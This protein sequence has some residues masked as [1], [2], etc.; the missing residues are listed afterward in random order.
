MKKRLRE[1]GTQK[2]RRI[3]DFRIRLCYAKGVITED[4]TLYC[5]KAAKYEQMVCVHGL[6]DC[7]CVCIKRESLGVR[8]HIRGF[9]F[10]RISLSLM[11]ND[12]PLKRVA[13]E[14]QADVDQFAL[15]SNR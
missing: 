10:L 7:R 15:R 1:T 14:E 4:Y 9:F 6:N 8:R 2:T 3:F 5:R 12:H 11:V 13:C